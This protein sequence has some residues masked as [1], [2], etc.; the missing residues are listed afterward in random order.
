MKLRFL[1]LIPALTIVILLASCGSKTNT[2][3]KMI[4]KTAGFV[5]TFN[6][7][8]IMAKAN[9][10]AV[11]A[12]DWHKQ[13]MGNAKPD[14]SVPEVIRNFNGDLSVLGIDSN[15]N[16]NVFVEM[17]NAGER[18]MVLE[19]GISDAKKFEALIRQSSKHP[20]VRKEGDIQYASM[21]RN[22]I[23]TWNNE[24]FVAA[25]KN[26]GYSYRDYTLG[27]KTEDP[28]NASELK[29]YCVKLYSLGS[30]DNLT[31]DEHFSELMKTEGD[32][33]AWSS[34]EN[35]MKQ[36]EA[37]GMMAMLKLDEL[38]KD[39]VNT[40]TV[41]FE[42]GKMSLT[43]KSYMNKKMAD[44]VRKNENFNADMVRYI[45]SNDVPVAIGA[46]I[47]PESI[48]K[49]AELSGLDGLINLMM[50]RTAGFSLSD[51]LN[52]TNG[53]FMIAMTD[54]V[55][56]N[57]DSIGMVPVSKMMNNKIVIAIGVKDQEMLNKIIKRFSDEV[58]DSSMHYTMSKNYLVL[59]NDE[60]SMIQYLAGNKH[61]QPFLD[62][63][64][65]KP[66]G[67]YINIHRLIEISEPSMHDSLAHDIWNEANKTWDYATFTGG[68]YNDGGINMKV[69][70]NMT[71]KNTSSLQQLLHFGGTMAL[72]AKEEV[73]KRDQEFNNIASDTEYIRPPK[74]VKPTQ[75]KKMVKK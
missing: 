9:M 47:N 21:D 58:K 60:K 19:G 55:K 27:D 75:P 62:K 70:V 59:S 8:T 38:M 29:A 72:S 48:R 1:N 44:I 15:A 61:D 50:A 46:H 5:M 31:R 6:L 17:G 67:G 2:E 53:D 11:F 41:N 28:D 39:N 34:T 26:E 49:I 10:H 30:S 68:D 3:G 63:I 52:A 36:N 45:P 54:P 32:I 43:M 65:G 37:M 18:K 14:S 25:V 20:D 42:K 23:L 71:D 24:H 4:P 12:E 7:K 13:L 66:M 64:S 16:I 35:L 33:H 40:Y 56:E 69:E 22:T 51:M 57:R 74:I 73:K